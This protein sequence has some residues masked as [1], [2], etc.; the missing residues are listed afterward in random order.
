MENRM[1][2]K[3]LFASLLCFTSL[4]FAGRA[5]PKDC[6]DGPQPYRLGVRHIEGNGI[7]YNRGYT[8]FE[9]FF[10]SDVNRWCVMPFLDA[11]AHVFD[12]GK[13]AANAGFGARGIW[14]DRIYGINAYYDYRNTKHQHYNQVAMGLETLGK[15]W[16][17]RLNGYLPVGKKGS[18]F[19]NADFS[20]FTGHSM[21]VRR[22]QQFAMKGADAEIGA[23]LNSS[24]VVPF[25]AAIGP[26]YFKGKGHNAYGGKFRL[27]A[28][29]R[30]YIWIE[31][32]I[33]Y[34]NIFK[35]I[36]QGQVAFTLPLG[37]K[38]KI[39]PRK[40]I[41]CSDLNHLEHLMVQ[42]VVRTEIIPVDSRKR[43]TNPSF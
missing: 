17:I 11:R 42:R 25:Y 23:H 15:W 2:K 14:G 29:Y 35:D 6:G 33:S 24:K 16:D 37:K 39:K 28:Q 7:G 27:N 26:Y 40:N 21:I 36:Y 12:D 5:A 20:H 13:W 43:L 32:S 30:D 8:T 22:K 1:L 38:T 18:P 10:A 31:G 19:F 34:D 3:S 4:S 41:N 9:G